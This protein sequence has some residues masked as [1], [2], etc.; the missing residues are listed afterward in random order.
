MKELTP[1]EQTIL[2]SIGNLYYEVIPME[3]RT[4]CSLTSAISKAVLA[5]FGI[6]SNVI[7]CQV[8]YSVPDHNFVIGF[9]GHAPRDG[10][11][12]GHAICTAGNWFIDAALTHF[13]TEFNLDIP[14]VAVGERFTLPTQAI[15]RVDLSTTQRLWWH[16]P[17]HGVDTS[18]PINPPGLVGDYAQRLIEK[19]T[20]QTSAYRV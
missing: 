12:D 13:K 15:S 4:Y 7:P 6:E 19:M 5:H 16:H 11:W 1:V 18:I 3:L 8:W 2:R 14:A 20:Q 17:P 10:K 9:V